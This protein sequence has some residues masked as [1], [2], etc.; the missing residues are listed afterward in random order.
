MLAYRSWASLTSERL[1]NTASASSKSSTASVRSASEK[2]RS[3]FFS[4]SPTYLST[5]EESRTT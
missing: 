1:P 2:T 4:V 3:R 5:T